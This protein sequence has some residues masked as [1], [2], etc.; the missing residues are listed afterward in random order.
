[1]AA[2]SA[3]AA[4]AVMKTSGTYTMKFISSVKQGIIS[5]QEHEAGEGAPPL[6]QAKHPF[7]TVQFLA[8][9]RRPVHAA[10]FFHLTFCNCTKLAEERPR[11]HLPP[12]MTSLNWPDDSPETI[13]IY[14]PPREVCSVHVHFRS[15]TFS[16]EISGV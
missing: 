14:T 7:Q 9:F 5:G 1:M 15:S 10:N 4:S 13:E 6:N 8:I 3:A 12:L 2:A 16:L 11:V